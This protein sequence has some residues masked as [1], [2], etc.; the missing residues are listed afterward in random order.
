MKH[1]Y[2]APAVEIVVIDD[3][4]IMASP[5]RPLRMDRDNASDNNGR[6]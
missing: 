3:E 4:N 1:E 2:E 5:E 6:L